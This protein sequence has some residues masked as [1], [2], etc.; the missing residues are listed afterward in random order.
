MDKA[1]RYPGSHPFR[2]TELDRQLFFGRDQER[3]ALKHLIL[4]ERLVVLF[5]KSGMGKTSLLNAGVFSG[6]RAR[7]LRAPVDPDESP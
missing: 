5:A 2:D 4:S 7:N 6:L 1:Y 3:E